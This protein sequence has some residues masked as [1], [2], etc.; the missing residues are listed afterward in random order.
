MAQFS[1]TWW[2]QRFIAAL[3][4]FT[5]PG[6]LSRGRAYAGDNRILDYKRDGGKVRAKVRGNINPYFGVY[7]E[8][9]YTTRVSFTPIGDKEWA[10]A[11]ERIGSRADLITKLLMGE[12]PDNI[13]EVFADRGLHLLPHNRQDITTNCSCPDWENPCKHVAG[14]YNRL[15]SSLDDDPFILFEL[16]GLPRERL[17]QQ[18]ARS[19]LGRI[20]A[21]ALEPHE[22][23]IEPA[24]S[25]FTAPTRE[26]LDPAV[27]HRE[28]WQG[29][30]RL[31]PPP[32][33][34]APQVPALLVK[35]Q[36]D[37]PAFWLKD[38]SFI[39]VME[40]LYERVRVKSPELK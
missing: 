5:D 24:S 39:D 14:V 25:F 2:G 9:I 20:L 7:E 1:R 32:A 17:R 34:A 16:R 18:L 31:P 19:P 30:R 28:F 3:E 33:P 6:R 35:K 29:A 4:A 12:V 13:D 23:P 27:G 40:A 38:T 15:A 36:G 26:P 21:S 37:Y 8:P 11:I 10:G 22:M